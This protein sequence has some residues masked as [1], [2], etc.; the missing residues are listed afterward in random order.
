M[1]DKKSNIVKNIILA[2]L[3]IMVGI[4]VSV[5]FRV[6]QAQKKETKLEE[7]RKLADYE[8]QIQKLTQD[9]AVL[10]EEYQSNR[11]AYAKELNFLA[12][13]DSTFYST[14]KTYHDS[15]NSL[16]ADAGL[17]DVKGEGVTVTVSDS[18]NASSDVYNSTFVVHDTTLM[19]LVNDLKLA[20]AEAISVNDERIVAM[21]EFF[22]VGPAVKVNGTK[23][24]APFTIKAIGVPSKLEAAVRESS[25]FTNP[26]IRLNLE[27]TQEKELYVEAYNKAYRNN[28][29][30]LQDYE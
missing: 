15:I 30:L 1:A 6:V 22:C 12:E 24:F 17:T 2:F 21:T 18:I 25:V 27:I 4:T 9:L 8:A 14:L 16:K 19:Q 26:N 3:M 29:V 11:D 13:N 20:G 7:S 28:I 5:Q 10:R 23:L